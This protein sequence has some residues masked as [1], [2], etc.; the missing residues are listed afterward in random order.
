MTSVTSSGLDG[1]FIW[2]LMG[3][4]HWFDC[5]VLKEQGW[6]VSSI[7]RNSECTSYNSMLSTLQEQFRNNPFK[8]QLTVTTAQSQVHEDMEET[9]WCE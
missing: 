9:V 5:F 1:E 2:R 8:N 6:P 4:R 3:E 7:E